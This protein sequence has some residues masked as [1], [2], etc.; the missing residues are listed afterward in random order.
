MKF[1]LSTNWSN[2]RLDD[3]AAIA[4]EAGE[5]G[6]DSLELGFRT[7]SSQLPGF[8]SRLDVMPVES[9]HA[10]CPAPVSA[11]SGHPE[12][13]RLCSSNENECAMARMLLEKT[14]SCAA[15]L[16]ANT[17]VFHAGY[18]SMDTLFGDFFTTARKLRVK[19]GRKVYDAFRRGFDILRPSLETK[20]LVLAL[21]NLPSL[22]GFPNVFEAEE[23]MREFDG[24]P[25]RLW[26][27]TGHA[28]VCE[29]NGWGAESVHMAA[30]LA[31]W[32]RG[33]H[34]NDV[35]GPSD[36]H[37][38]PGWGNVDYAGLTFLAKRDV[39][40]VFEPSSSVL[41]DDLRNSLEY[42]RNMW[43]GCRHSADGVQES[44]FDHKEELT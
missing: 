16:G 38:E 33:M 18:A 20:G 9:V 24:A 32:I 43:N 34:L 22:E 19:R 4:D 41:A 40:R 29:T 15:D 23:L 14:F 5:L 30:R 3:G 6:F 17:I 10:Y 31:P 42:I 26:F 1:A 25:L 2:T 36:D 44:A 28:L 37:G 7:R 12:L 35:K 11:P 27:D 39:L 13:Y 8:K 21:E